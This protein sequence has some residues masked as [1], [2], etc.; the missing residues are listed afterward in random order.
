MQ[1]WEKFGIWTN[2]PR[3]GNKRPYWYGAYWNG[4]SKYAIV[5]SPWSRHCQAKP[6]YDIYEIPP[7]FIGN[8]TMVCHLKNPLIIDINSLQ[9]AIEQVQTLEG[10]TN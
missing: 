2:Q 9:E 1:K 8:D 7:K 10:N 4:V 5:T 3:G 6:R